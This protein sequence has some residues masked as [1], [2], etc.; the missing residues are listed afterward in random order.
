M[1]DIQNLKIV[2]SAIGNRIYGTLG[3]IEGRCL[4]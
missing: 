3:S 4:T 1:S 2:V